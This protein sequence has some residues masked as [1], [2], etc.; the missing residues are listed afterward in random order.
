MS[1][2]AAPTPHKFD[3]ELI[4]ELA[5]CFGRAAVDEIIEEQRHAAQRKSAKSRKKKHEGQSQ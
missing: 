3:R 2:R 1:R 5:M 4:R